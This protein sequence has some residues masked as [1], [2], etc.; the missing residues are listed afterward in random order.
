MHR[1]FLVAL[2]IFA[3]TGVH[4]TAQN[5]D[6]AQ[7]KAEIVINSSHGWPTRIIISGYNPNDAAWLGMSF[8]P[9]GIDDY[10]TG[11]RHNFLEIKK[12]N[13]SQVFQIDK[14]LL[15]GS[16][17]FG[18]WAKKVDKVDCTEEYCYWC[19]MF[20]FHVEESLAYASGLLTQQSGYNK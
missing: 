19:K 17:E 2:I 16:F 4:S 11:G 9:Y 15:G 7:L 20:G 6:D 10:I 8:Y 5:K 1:F 18:L 3:F 12:G 13:F 14:D